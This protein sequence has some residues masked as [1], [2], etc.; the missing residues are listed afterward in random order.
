MISL[1]KALCNVQLL[2]SARASLV[3]A[4]TT[5]TTLYIS[6]SQPH[7]DF[8]LTYELP[9]REK[10]EWSRNCTIWVFSQNLIQFWLLKTK[11]NKIV[12]SKRKELTYV[13]EKSMLA[14][15]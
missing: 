10:R 3:A 1:L 12:I 4:L 6:M 14:Q 11:Q 13:R 15:T 5:P 2:M 7:V 9:V 8:V